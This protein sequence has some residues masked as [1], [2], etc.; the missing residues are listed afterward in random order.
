MSNH[1]QVTPQQELKPVGHGVIHTWPA[2]VPLC[3]V[4]QLLG[5]E[6][7][8]AVGNSLSDSSSCHCA[9]LNKSLRILSQSSYNT[10]TRHELEITSQN[11]NQTVAP[12]FSLH[13]VYVVR[14]YL[15]R[16]VS[17]HQADKLASQQPITVKLHCYCASQ[18]IP[19]HFHSRLCNPSTFKLQQCHN[20]L[21]S[22]EA[23]VREYILFNY[24][25]IYATY[26]DFGVHQDFQG[27]HQALAIAQVTLNDEGSEEGSSP[28]S[29]LE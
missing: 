17:M 14:L 12:Y 15:V 18:G 21:P 23:N 11:P 16:I 2:D 9:N 7:P 28:Q 10:E 5:T 13:F 26:T 8:R 4:K 6:L 27:I 25:Q 3:S 19:V 22:N 29:W 20:F 1:K 24:I